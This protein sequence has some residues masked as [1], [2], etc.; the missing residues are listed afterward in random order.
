MTAGLSYRP[1]ANTAIKFDY[2]Y[3]WLGSGLAGMD[4]DESETGLKKHNH[5]FLFGVTTGF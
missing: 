2:Q 1:V 5:A 4:Y 3:D